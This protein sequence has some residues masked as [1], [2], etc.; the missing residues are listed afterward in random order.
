MSTTGP[1]T[2]PVP[3]GRVEAFS[4][5]VFAVAITLLVLDITLAH[6]AGRG[7]LWAEL[8][9]LK[10]HYAAYAISFLT[11]GIMW[12]SHHHLM[13]KLATVDHAL[14][15][16]NLALLAVICFIPFPTSVLSE[17]VHGQGGS[18]MRAAVSLYGI[19]LTALSV[20]FLALWVHVYR[21]PEIRSA[22]VTQ[23]DVRADTLRAGVS[24]VL[25][26]VATALTPVAPWVSLGIFTALVIVYA[27]AR[28]RARPPEDTT[29]TKI[30]ESP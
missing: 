23:S 13:T 2:S 20:A 3:K 30:A 5:G 8:G 4:D 10:Y 7:R 26:V 24:F 21:S 16:R 6:H 28:P 1:R 25:D 22:G 29:Q 14:L 12:V 27:V 18:N 11:I 15:Y 17:Y 19:T 9:E